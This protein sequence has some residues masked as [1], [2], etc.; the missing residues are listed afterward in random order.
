MDLKDKIV[1]ILWGQHLGQ[2]LIQTE[3]GSLADVILR[4]VDDH[5]AEDTAWFV[6][7]IN[8]YRQLCEELEIEVEVRTNSFS[9]QPRL[10]LGFKKK[11]E[12]Y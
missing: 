4:E 7:Q 9:R 12:D 2:S 10:N 8:H 1:A 11:K 3:A 5:M 6:E